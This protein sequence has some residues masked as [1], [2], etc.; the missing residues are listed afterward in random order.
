MGPNLRPEPEGMGKEKEGLEKAEA[1][2]MSFHTAEPPAG[3]VLTCALGSGP[4]S[5]LPTLPRARIP[6]D[7]TS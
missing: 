6:H 7:G 4:S 2:G 5:L 1:R 3:W